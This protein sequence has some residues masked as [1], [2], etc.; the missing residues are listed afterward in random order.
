MREGQSTILISVF[1]GI[2]GGI[3]TQRVQIEQWTEHHYPGFLE[4]NTSG[5]KPSTA[6]NQYSLDARAKLYMSITSR[7]QAKMA[8]EKREHFLADLRSRGIIKE[9]T[10]EEKEASRKR[11]EEEANAPFPWLLI[12]GVIGGLLTVMALMGGGIA[13]LIYKYAD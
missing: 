4:I 11:L 9:Q 10:E 12:I 7:I 5:D 2:L 3:L 13:F 1:A 8:A 6:I